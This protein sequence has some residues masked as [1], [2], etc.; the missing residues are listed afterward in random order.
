MI[1]LAAAAAALLERMAAV[2]PD[3]HAFTATIRAHVTM[4]SFPFLSADLEGTYYFKSPD[5]NKVVFTSGVPMVAQQ[6]DKL[7]AHIDSP[8]AWREKYDV[9]TLSDDG[10]ST[11]FK[12]VPR[13]HGQRRGDRR[14][15]RRQDRD[16][17]V[18]AL[19][20][21]ITAAMRR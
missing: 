12:L 13:K 9:T 19:A 20:L 16:G 14:H 4:K 6:F 1:L 10:G 11:R 17:H 21:S 2:N 7:Y 18:D 3:L 8:S 15:G 5:K